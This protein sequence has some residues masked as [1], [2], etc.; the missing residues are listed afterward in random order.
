MAGDGMFTSQVSL[1]GR[2]LVKLSGSFGDIV[3]DPFDGGR[4]LSTGELQKIL[5]GMFGGGVKLLEPAG[6]VT[7]ATEFRG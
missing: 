4:V 7:L 1:P 6:M 2:F 3:I 5:D